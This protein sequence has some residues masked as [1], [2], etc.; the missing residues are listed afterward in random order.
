MHVINKILEGVTVV[1]GAALVYVAL[2]M[3]ALTVVR[4]W[5]S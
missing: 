4:Y 1:V 5:P 2:V 3:V